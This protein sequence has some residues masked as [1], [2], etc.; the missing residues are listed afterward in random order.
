MMYLFIYKYNINL[1]YKYNIYISYISYQY[2]KKYQDL[3]D[4]NY[5]YFWIKKIAGKL[6]K[7]I[8]N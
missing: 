1:I 8:V 4:L 5:Y 3:K 6:L 7:I 2:L